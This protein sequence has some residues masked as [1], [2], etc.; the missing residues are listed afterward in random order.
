MKKSEMA[1]FSYLWHYSIFIIISDYFHE[2]RQTYLLL[3]YV[4]FIIDLTA[5]INLFLGKKAFRISRFSRPSLKKEEV[6]MGI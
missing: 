1:L 3:G 2:K 6:L 4:Y 5:Q